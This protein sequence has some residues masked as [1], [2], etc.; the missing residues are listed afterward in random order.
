M[1]MYMYI[2]SCSHIKGKVF[3]LLANASLAVFRRFP[4]N[5]PTYVYTYR[6]YMYIRTCIINTYTYCTCTCIAVFY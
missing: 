1:Y 2:I 4:G 6:T 3:V 5:T